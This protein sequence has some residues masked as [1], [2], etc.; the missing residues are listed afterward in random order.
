MNRI[1][2]EDRWQ[3]FAAAARQGAALVP[4]QSLPSQ[5]PQGFVARVVARA[6]LARAEFVALLWERWSWRMALLTVLLA[7]AIG[8]LVIFRSNQARLDVPTQTLDV[9]SLESP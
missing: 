2:P 5:A 8:S 9:P 7:V 4:A 3:R 1:E 6:M